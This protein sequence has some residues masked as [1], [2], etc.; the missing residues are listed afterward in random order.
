M[1]I[2]ETLSAIIMLALVRLFSGMCS[3]MN[4]QGTFLDEVLSASRDRAC[5]RPLIRVDS[6]MSLQISL[7][8]ETLCQLS[9]RDWDSEGEDDILL[10]RIANHI[11]MDER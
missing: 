1:Y 5:V 9:A 10:C 3:D 11:G 4:G 6:I 2:R 8:V 7:T